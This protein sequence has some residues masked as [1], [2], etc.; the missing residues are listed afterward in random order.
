MLCERWHDLLEGGAIFAGGM[1]CSK[2]C[3]GPKN[4]R[5]F[6]LDCGD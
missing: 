5:S 6:F 1:K 2:D 3:L 4:D